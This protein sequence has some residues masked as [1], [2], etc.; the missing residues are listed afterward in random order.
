MSKSPMTQFNANL[1]QAVQRFSCFAIFVFK[2]KRTVC[3]VSQFYFAGDPNRVWG[4]GGI[5]HS[6]DFSDETGSTV[7]AVLDQDQGRSLG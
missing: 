5:K 3:S 4:P 7:R 6:L 1:P 2:L